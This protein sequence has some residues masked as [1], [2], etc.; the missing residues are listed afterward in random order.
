MEQDIERQPASVKKKT[1]EKRK[2]QTTSLLKTFAFLSVLGLLIFIAVC[3]APRFHSTLNLS[4]TT[5]LTPNN[6]EQRPRQ[7]RQSWGNTWQQQ[8]QIQQQQQQQQQLIQQQQQQVHQQQQQLLQQWYASGVPKLLTNNSVEIRKEDQILAGQIGPVNLC[9]Q[10][11]IKNS[12]PNLDYS[13]KGYNYLT[14]FP[15]SLEHDPGFSNQ[16]FQ[17]K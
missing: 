2:R 7:G 8:Q 13:L 12:F 3:S 10:P 6:P 5:S 4:R 11:T 17:V 14:G 9:D 16:I 15:I 1:A